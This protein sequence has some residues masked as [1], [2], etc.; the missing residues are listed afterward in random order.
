M[1]PYIGHESQLYGVEEH[2]L[3]GGKGDGMRLFEV[4]NG[5]GI[6]L[7]ISA[8]RCADIS[9][10][11]F[12][13]QNLSYMTACGYVA[14]AYYDSIG[15]NWLNSFTA[16][17]LTTCGFQNVGIPNE[18]EGEELPLHGSIGNTPAENIYYREEGDELCIYATVKDETIFGRKLVLKRKISVSTKENVIVITDR[19]LNTGDKDEQVGILYHM[20]M[21]Y[22]LLDE[23]SIITIPSNQVIARN[24][25]A[26]EDIQNWMKVEKPTPH[27]EERCYYHYF[28][29]EKGYAS[30]EQPKSGMK[31]EIS[32]DAKS[33]DHFVQWKMMGVRDYV[34]GLECGNTLPEGRAE[35][36]KRGQLKFV[37][38]GESLEYKVTIRLS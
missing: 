27:Y 29:D 19:I 35:M 16:G 1:N 15:A 6:D 5:K 24:A 33:L 10:L 18:D 36:R 2:R 7:T 9:R 23:D 25:H 21:G 31:L 22:P 26:Q 28:K 3:V 13:G 11:R 37:K 12:K 34:M 38:P 8:D 17:F 32:Y 14:P 4:H 20:N 30:I